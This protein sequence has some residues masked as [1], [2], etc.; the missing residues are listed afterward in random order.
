[1]TDIFDFLP[2]RYPFLM[3]DRVVSV[4]TLEIVALKNITNN[5][6]YFQG[7]FPGNPILPGVFILE[8]MFQAGGLLNIHCAKSKKD[9]RA[10]SAYLTQIS[11]AKFNKP[12]IPGDQLYVKV[13]VLANMGSACKFIGK[14]YVDDVIVAE[15]SWMSMAPKEE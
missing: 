1:M 5:E 12:V 6:S 8:S 10:T 4:D 7:H 9:S 11:K 13:S 15:A 2:H 3:I 14:A